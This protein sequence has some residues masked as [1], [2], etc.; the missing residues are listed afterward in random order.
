[1]KNGRNTQGRLQENSTHGF[2]ARMLHDTKVE[3]LSQVATGT[4]FIKY[5]QQVNVIV[6]RFSILLHPLLLQLQYQIP[7]NDLLLAVDW[8]LVTIIQG[9]LL[10]G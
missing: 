10:A 1:M 4:Y 8:L 9:S 7:F 6:I 5:F 2:F 3:W